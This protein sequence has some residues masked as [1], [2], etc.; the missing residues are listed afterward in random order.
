MS[1][2]IYHQ[3]FVFLVS[4]TQSTLYAFISK[5][6]FDSQNWHGRPKNTIQSPNAL[7]FQR[8]DAVRSSVM[9]FFFSCFQI[10]LPE[11]QGGGRPSADNFSEV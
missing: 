5:H 10:N 3:S 1:L 7:A 2:Y 9:L 8:Y 11:Y 6:L 4:F